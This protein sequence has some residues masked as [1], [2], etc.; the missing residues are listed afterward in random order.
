M[1]IKDLKHLVLKWEG[2]DGSMGRNPHDAAAVYPC[3]TPYIDPK[4]KK[5]KY[6]WHTVEGITYRTW[7]GTFG[8]KADD[9]FFAMNDEDW[10]KVFDEKFFKKV[11]GKESYSSFNVLAVITD[12]SFMSGAET[13]IINLQRAILDCGGLLP[14]FGADGSIGSES[15]L[16]MNKLNP[17][18]LIDKIVQRRILFLK[19]IAKK[20]HNKDFLKG[21][22]NRTND[23][24]ISYSKEI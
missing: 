8:K 5:L 20:G 12:I 10:S 24:L 9:R 21:W 4:D 19:S 22:I 7:V 17:K 13:A 6:D 16:A 11:G 23:Y 1:D 15:I 2:G 14:K 18:L 3:P